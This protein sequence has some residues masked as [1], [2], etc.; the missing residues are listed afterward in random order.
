MLGLTS[1]NLV[2]VFAEGEEG[3]IFICPLFITHRCVSQRSRLDS[4]CAFRSFIDD[5]PYFQLTKRSIF[6]VTSRLPCLGG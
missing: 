4:S 3:G 6:T 1:P 5:V 2:L